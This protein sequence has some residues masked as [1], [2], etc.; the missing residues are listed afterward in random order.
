MKFVVCGLCIG[1]RYFCYVVFVLFFIVLVWLFW[2]FICSWYVIW[3][4]DYFVYVLFGCFLAFSLWFC[5]VISFWGRE[6]FFILVW[7]CLCRDFCFVIKFIGS[8]YLE[9]G[10]VSSWVIV[11]CVGVSY[12]FGWKVFLSVIRMEFVLN[13]LLNMNICLC[14]NLKFLIGL[15]WYKFCLKMFMCI[16]G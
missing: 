15:I 6:W 16:I 1:V 12:V 2:N 8:G 10:F 5:S 4:G 3:N 14:M 9:Y 11:G 13:K 7:R